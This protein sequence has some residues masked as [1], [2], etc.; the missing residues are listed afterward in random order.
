MLK[1]VFFI[2]IVLALI[3]H[4][5]IFLYGLHSGMAEQFLQTWKSFGII[6]TEYSIFIFKHFMWFWL[7]PVI[8]LILMSISL[9]YSK[10]RLA[11]FTV[12]I[13]FVFDIVVYWSVYSP[14]LMVKM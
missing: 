2:L 5:S 1:K 11:M 7:L 3:T 13:V 4:Q 9:F 14:D 6:Q 12:F 10:K 8:S